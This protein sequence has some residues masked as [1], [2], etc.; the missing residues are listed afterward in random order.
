MLEEDIKS[1]YLVIKRKDNLETPITNGLII[2][3]GK[4]QIDDTSGNTS[5]NITIEDPE[6]ITTTGKIKYSIEIR[7]DSGSPTESIFERY[8]EILEI[9]EKNMLLFMNHFYDF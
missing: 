8:N 9:L 5:R 1:F 2:N 7:Q 6:Q 4:F 3:L